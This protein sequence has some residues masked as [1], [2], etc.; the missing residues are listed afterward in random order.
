MRKYGRRVLFY[1]FFTNE[2]RKWNAPVSFM[3]RSIRIII[4]KRQKMPDEN[5]WRI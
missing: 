1:N 4:F 2:E 3:E 5:D